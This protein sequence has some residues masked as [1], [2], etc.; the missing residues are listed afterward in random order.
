MT[1]ARQ[2]NLFA[3]EDWKIAYK[4][5][6][7]V[8]FQ[9]YDFDT[10]R[11]AMV[12]YIKTNFP[13]NFNDYIESSE[14]IA[15][16]ELLAFLSQSLAFRID[17]N[18]R[19][20]FLETAERRDSVFKLARMLGYNP[21]RN[22][23]A[24]GLMKVVSI[25]T[26]EP[27]T[28]SLGAQLSNRIIYWD[29]ENNNQS[30]EQFITILNAAMS[31]SNR[32]TTPIK[33]GTVGGV[34]TELY[35][36]NT[37][38]GSPI[39]YNF[40]LRINGG[41]KPFN[42]CNPDFEDNGYFYER[43]PDPTNLFN[44]IYRNDTKGLN[45]IDTGFFLFFRQ[46]ILNFENFNYTVPVENRIQNVDAANIN[47]SDVYLQ[48]IDT[49]GA[50]VNKWSKVPNTV[51]QTLNYNSIDLKTKN[52][53]S[54]ENN[55]SN[56][57]R[58][59]YPDGNFGNI[60]TGLFRLWY[61]VSD[62]T[63]YS[64]QPQNA[65]NVVIS[66]P[67]TNSDNEKHTISITCALQ[68]TVNNSLPAESIAAIKERAPQTFYTQNRMISA[69]D[70]NVFPQ[71]Q[72][73]NILKLKATNRTHAGHSRYI[74][75]NDPTGTYQNID[76]FAD[77]AFL[78]VDDDNI[79]STI[80]VNNNVTPLEVVTSLI[81]NKLKSQP[82]NNFVYYGLRNIWS[83]STLNGVTN[84]F[85]FS[86]TDNVVWNSLPISYESKTGYITEQFSTGASSVLVNVVAGKTT[87]LKQNN[88]IKWANPDN[89]GEYK[90]ARIVSV[91]NA[92]QLSSGLATSQGPW[93][94]SEEIISGWRATDVVVSL[95]KTF[96]ATET[97]L[98]Q[99]Q[100][101]DRNSFGLGYDLIA[102]A[103]YIIPGDTLTNAVKTGNFGL[104][105]NQRGPNSWLVLMEYSPIDQFSY[106]YNITTRGQDYI[107][108][109]KDN[110]RFYNISDVKILGS[111]NKSQRDYITF[112]TVNTQSSQTE[113][114]GWTGNGFLN[115]VTGT[116]HAP[117]GLSVNL[118]LKT[119]DTS[120]KDI[121]AEWISNFGIFGIDG[122]TLEEHVLVNRY[123][124][125]TS[126]AL[127]TYF[128]TGALTTESNLV[129]AANTGL[130]NLLPAKITIPFSNTTFGENIVDDSGTPYIAYRQ[131]ITNGA[132]GSEVVFKAEAGQTPVSYGIAGTVLDTSEE[133]RLFLLDY[134]INSQRGNI[135]YR[136]LQNHDLHYSADRT[137]AFSQ[138]KLAITY[139]INKDKLEQ[140]IQWQISSVFKEADGYTDPRKVRVAPI[141]SD[142]DLV[143]DRPLQFAEY[144]GEK[145]LILMEYYADFDGFI[146]DRP[147][148][149]V[150][151][152]FRKEPELVISGSG[153]TVSPSRYKD[154]YMLSQV[155][156]IIT[157]NDAVANQFA[158][159]SAANGIVIH[160]VDSG[161]TF[162]VMPLSTNTSQ[163][164]VAETEDYFVR[165]GRGKNQNTLITSNSDGI[166]RWQHA[167][168]SGVRIDPSISNIID[169]TVLTQSYNDAVNKWKSTQAGEFPREPTTDQLNLEFSDINTYKAASDTMIF[170]S[171]K[172]KLL[173]GNAADPTYQAK[174]RVV[175]L[176][177]Q[178][179]DNEL[180]SRIVS[181]I[182]NYFDVNN[183]EFG[184]IFYFTELSTYIHQQ[185]G[186]AIGSIV[187]LPKNVTGK[188]GELFQVKAES[189]ELFI[190]TATV[191]DIEIISRL[192]SQTLKIN[193]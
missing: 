22:V 87:N 192:D 119:R 56:G 188:F 62:P 84:I 109:S 190:S 138:D 78:Y 66:I 77:D 148:E 123:V 107:I 9:A 81:P 100:I 85:K 164:I 24:S 149:G 42:V 128:R 68:Y 3:A 162:Q 191:N 91:E 172:F 25:K 45:S 118:P 1:V 104:D 95:R 83:D 182:N 106:Q 94:L 152:D 177:D 64:I 53:Y 173:F 48:E 130:I 93:V 43:H 187:I 49:L 147:I 28:D 20:N 73:S 46:G 31:R 34:N 21:K 131:K 155:D 2:Q 171:S 6:N 4:V 52:L 5:Y 163:Y 76:T 12:E 126:I 26:T 18:T 96:T 178:I 156:W 75:I 158:N 165:S 41:E 35:Q 71:S 136:S 63:R 57:L 166:V 72:S 19:E 65:R 80:V 67:Y 88:F 59:R 36:L 7:N 32:F 150:I 185:L 181:T 180:K 44:L 154:E 144:V 50:V 132:D 70:Y 141:D 69:Q 189:N 157:K 38:A 39:A 176:S 11:L 17:V 82:I 142:N 183:W 124:T 10:M 122:N 193:T 129:V 168:P 40:S 98:I 161:K 30:Y 114:F 160:S 167:A 54:V 175:K 174:F 151:L 13:E 121:E 108:Q 8:D 89:L 102:D 33:S 139:L 51:G 97:T 110:L 137:G 90:W 27:I 99:Q 133:G 60:P 16:I 61:R 186:S 29:D 14:F 135:E 113:T 170:R 117:F 134:D 112:S 179:S 92:G 111:N 153:G 169:M 55:S 37:P 145:D 103:W 58:L 120:W 23:P 101:K 125:E 143:P 115:N 140:P 15:I 47:E 127:N 105:E 74:D 159:I 116:A 146:Y 86:A 184:E 79:S